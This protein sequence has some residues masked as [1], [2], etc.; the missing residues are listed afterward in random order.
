MNPSHRKFGNKPNSN[1]L[2]ASERLIVETKQDKVLE[3][4]KSCQEVFET[5]EAAK[6]DPFG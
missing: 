1:S 3:I 4:F 5:L 6:R 2:L